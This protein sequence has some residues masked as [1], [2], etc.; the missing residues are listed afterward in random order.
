[1]HGAGMGVNVGEMLT[2]VE[3]QTRQRHFVGE[4]QGEIVLVSPS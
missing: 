2:F 3:N 1:M 4:S